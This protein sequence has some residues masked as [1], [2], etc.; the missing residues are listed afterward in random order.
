M[1]TRVT[2]ARRVTAVRVALPPLAHAKSTLSPSQANAA[3]WLFASR[4]IILPLSLNFRR[5]GSSQSENSSAMWNTIFSCFLNSCFV[6]LGGIETIYFLRALIKSFFFVTHRAS[7][8]GN[9]ARDS[10][11]RARRLGPR[12][13]VWAAA[14]RWP[15]P[16]SHGHG[17]AWSTVFNI[18]PPGEGQKT[19][20]YLQMHA[21]NVSFLLYRRIRNLSFWDMDRLFFIC[22]SNFPTA[23]SRFYI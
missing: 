3:R 21:N 2:L 17:P 20:K 7:A 6:S 12:S 14:G 11:S 23:M 13:V 5:N 9:V 19:A 4:P 18:E 8:V 15:S 1:T 16:V 22:R 10:T